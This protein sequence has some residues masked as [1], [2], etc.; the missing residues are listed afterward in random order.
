ME[1]KIDVNNMTEEQTRFYYFSM[2]DLNK[3]Q[4]IDGIEI[5]KALTHD[6]E[7]EKGTHKEALKLCLLG[8]GVAFE[9]EEK[10]I[11]MID[12][13]LNDLDLNGDG[14][15]DYAEYSRKHKGH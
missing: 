2:H 4:V 10:L 14:V 7:N 9:D 13:V 3:D 8:P 6:H 5:L 11:T 1:D 15:V 12:A